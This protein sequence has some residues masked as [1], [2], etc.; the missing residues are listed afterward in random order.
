MFDTTPP[1]LN[2]PKVIFFKNKIQYNRSEAIYIARSGAR[3]R[4]IDDSEKSE[5]TSTSM[6]NTINHLGPNSIKT[7]RKT[8]KV[9]LTN[10]LLLVCNVKSS[11][12]SKRLAVAEVIKT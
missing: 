12:A 2:D 10:D 1:D 6:Q 4:I 9:I 7:T 8:I 5:S 11:G 3:R